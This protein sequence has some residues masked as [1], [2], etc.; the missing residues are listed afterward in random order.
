M[1]ANLLV[2]EYRDDQPDGVEYSPVHRACIIGGK[3]LDIN[4]SSTVS[5]ITSQS[6]DSVANSLSS[7]SRSS[8]S[9][10]ND[11]TRATDISAI[12]PLG[13]SAPRDCPTSNGTRFTITSP[14][15]QSELGS[16]T[17][18]VYEK[19]CGTNMEATNKTDLASFVVNSFDLCIQTCAGQR[20]SMPVSAIYHWGDG[21]KDP[22]DMTRPG[23]CWCCGGIEPFTEKSE[24]C[25]TVVRN[26]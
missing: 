23:T 9:T 12:P 2:Y 19:I 11:V 18:I 24:R 15:D 21:T 4:N 16:G 7:I 8:K 14:F 22:T 10:T 3:H 25:D 26:P 13:R 5:T 1:W 6:R 20:S 17:T